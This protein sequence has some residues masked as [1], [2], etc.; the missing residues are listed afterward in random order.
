[1]RVEVKLT[2]VADSATT[3]T[4]LM[5]KGGDRQGWLRSLPDSQHQSLYT[6]SDEWD[7]K[8]VI[9][10][11]AKA[12]KVTRNT[13]DLNGMSF[14]CFKTLDSSPNLSRSGM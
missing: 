9:G 3:A 7:S 8:T 4:P 14:Y 11:K 2:H 1:M 5:Y 13:S 6:M 12:P 10:F